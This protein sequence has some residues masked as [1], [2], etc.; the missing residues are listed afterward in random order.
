L[1][2]ELDRAEVSGPNVG[3]SALANDSRGY[4]NPWFHGRYSKL[5]QR[6]VWV[7]G[8]RNQWIQRAALTLPGPAT[9]RW[10]IRVPKNATL[11]LDLGAA[12]M[13][14]M[15][16]QGLA[17]FAITVIDDGNRTILG[18][19]SVQSAPSD[20]P[21]DIK[22][23]EASLNAF[24]G[25]NIQL[26][27]S[28]DG[29]ADHEVTGLIF[30]P[31]ISAPAGES[32]EVPAYNVL[33]IVV[34]AQRADTVGAVAR[35]H[36]IPPLFPTMER[37]A[38]EG[39]QFTQ[40]FSVGNQ[41]RLSTFSFLSGQPPGHGRFH[42]SEWDF[43]PA[44]KAHYYAGDAPLLSRELRT[45]GYKT[46]AVGNN[47]FLFGHL[48]IGLDAGFDQVVD[49]RH[50]VRDTPWMT[51]T[52]IDWIT[53]NRDSRWMMM[54][55]YNSPHWPYAPPEESWKSFK[56][57]LRGIERFRWGYL[58]EINW[59]DEHIARVLE[60]LEQLDLA[61]NTLVLLTAD[62]GEIMDRR[63]DCY[64]DTIG[65]E[66]I[67][68][69]GMTLYDEETHVPM[70]F[71]QPG[72]VE[73]QAVTAPFSHVD[74]AP[75]VL[76]WAGFEPPKTQLG[77]SFKGALAGASPPPDAPILLQA[78][79]SV[80]MRYQGLK[81]IAHDPSMQVFFDNP[82][83]YDPLAGNEEVYDLRTDPEELNN[84]VG[85]IPHPLLNSLRTGL[86]H[87]RPQLLDE[88]GLVSRPPTTVFRPRGAKLSGRIVVAG[89][90]ASASIGDEPIETVG[91]SL[92]VDLNS[93]KELRFITNPPDAALTL[94]LS[95]NDTPLTPKQLLVGSFGLAL[96]ESARLV[97][98]AALGLSHAVKSPAT[99]S[100]GTPAVFM[101]R[102]GE[103]TGAEARSDRLDA[104]VQRMM[105]DWGYT[106][107]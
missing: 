87:L 82:N 70:I 59:V 60:T 23:F 67:F 48:E 81:Y 89:E 77:R 98:G 40:A 2:D 55:N 11:S 16:R 27:I 92:T 104:D 86:A 73:K 88:R 21:K 68:N 54:L 64:N 61:E 102:E 71:W 24:A 42:Q 50:R 83:Q 3:V 90:F 25:R 9:V 18:K 78:R 105:K 85:D 19:F 95:L 72:A 66:C 14:N 80:G 65:E 5:N 49:H 94:E 15:H 84:I 100:D 41:T 106:G 103:A 62:H 53:Q 93:L 57:K 1:L 99:S 22:S 69:H 8:S 29:A 33:L 35:Q 12:W 52:A 20:K 51:D 37:L 4:V 74:L 75:T 39:T 32:P 7:V 31:I 97:G 13:G 101:W 76:D 36:K 26:E 10:R 30:E 6:V 28:I 96:L 63:H 17:R 45:R 56:P 43:K 38:K 91:N 44:A 46:I 47:A 58:G 34:D 107:R 79:F